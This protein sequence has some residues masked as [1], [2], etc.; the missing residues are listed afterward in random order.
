MRA[1]PLLISFLLFFLLLGLM[2]LAR[3]TRPVRAALAQLIDLVPSCRVSSSRAGR[4]LVLTWARHPLAWLLP[5]CCRQMPR[6]GNAAG[7]TLWDLARVSGGAGRAEFPLTVES[8]ADR[9]RQRRL[10]AEST[11]IREIKNE[12]GMQRGSSSRA[13]CARLSTACAPGS[14][15]V[16]AWK[17][18]CFLVGTARFFWW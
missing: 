5:V 7:N 13:P 9:L 1:V 6:A 16:C 11:Y 4:C 8:F 10:S 12:I 15:G 17:H 3:P 18:G 14:H 2:P